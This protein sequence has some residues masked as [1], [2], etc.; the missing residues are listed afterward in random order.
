MATIKIEALYEI[1]DVVYFI[2][3]K[4]QNQYV[5]TGY[6]VRQTRTTYIVSHNGDEKYAYEFELSDEKDLSKL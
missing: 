1:G 5:V 2:T 3:D 4:E 6:I